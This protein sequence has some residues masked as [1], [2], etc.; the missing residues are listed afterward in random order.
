MHSHTARVTWER[1][2]EPFVDNLYSRRHVLRFDGGA[3]VAGS[4]SPGV[5]PVPMSDPAA[6]DPEEAFV[7]S[8]ASCHMLWF[9]S[10]AAAKQWRVDRYDE[11]RHRCV[12]HPFGRGADVLPFLSA[13]DLSIFKLSFGRPQDWVDLQAIVAARPDL[14]IELIEELLVAL[15]GPTMYPRVARLR[16]LTHE[17]P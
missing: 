16:S 2:E 15:R 17:R 10:L 8:I 14:D 7:A 5:V 13:E 4:S 11:I 3:E 1:G 12:Q 9:L 6:V